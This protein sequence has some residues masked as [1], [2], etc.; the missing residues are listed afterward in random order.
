MKLNLTLR[1]EDAAMLIVLRSPFGH[2]RRIFTPSCCPCEFG[3]DKIAETEELL[4]VAPF[5]KF[6]R[7]GSITRQ[8]LTVAEQFEANFFKEQDARLPPGY[9]P[10]YLC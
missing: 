7:E 8:V 10:P 2:F 3:Q 4:L 9:V 5:R 6:G 1:V